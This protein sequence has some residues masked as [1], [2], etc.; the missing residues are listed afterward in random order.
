MVVK[1]S[2]HAQTFYTILTEYG[3]LSDKYLVDSL[4]PYIGIVKVNAED[5]NE[6]T[7]TLRE[8]AR[9]QSARSGSVDKVTTNNYL[10]VKS[11]I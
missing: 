11:I 6:R 7:T 9:L 2:I 10:L 4:E 3:T 5:I 8:A 1:V